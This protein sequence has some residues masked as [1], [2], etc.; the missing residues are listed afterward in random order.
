LFPIL[1]EKIIEL[2]KEFLPAEHTPI[3]LKGATLNLK[4]STYSKIKT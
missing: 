4:V 2:K 1:Y 3:K